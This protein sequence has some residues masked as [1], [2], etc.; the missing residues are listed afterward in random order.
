[1][2]IGFRK[3]CIVCVVLIYKLTKNTK[4]F[5]LRSF[6]HY[7]PST[8]DRATP[9]QQQQHVNAKTWRKLFLGCL[10]AMCLALS[11]SFRFLQET[12]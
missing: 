12:G 11:Y 4:I 6:A 1:M 10:P 2:K 9:N 5:V 8:T 7:T 3:K